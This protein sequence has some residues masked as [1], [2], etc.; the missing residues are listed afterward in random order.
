M[1]TLLGTADRSHTHS[2]VRLFAV[3][4]GAAA[5]LSLLTA[6][7]DPEPTG[8]VHPYYEAEFDLAMEAADTDLEKQ[9]LEDYV[10]TRDE[11]LEIKNVSVECMRSYGLTV[12]LQDTGAGLFQM[13]VGG[14]WDDDFVNETMLT[15]ETD[16]FR[17]IETLYTDIIQNPDRRDLNGLTAECL[18]AVGVVDSPFTG[19]DYERE[20]AS[21][22]FSTRIIDDPEGAKCLQNPSYHTQN[23]SG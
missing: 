7:T 2:R 1:M 11:Y 18:V 17:A 19:S 21:A 22:G 14:S 23:G 3:L 20:S 16:G 4:A 9:V 10:I 12:E 6:C 15:C 8:D 5:A 13:A